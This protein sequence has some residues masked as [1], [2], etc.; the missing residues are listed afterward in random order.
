V[1][2]R[3]VGIVFGVHSDRAE[4]QLGCGADDSERDLTA[5]SDQQARHVRSFSK[6][7]PVGFSVDPDPIMP[8]PRLPDYWPP[9]RRR[10]SSFIAGGW[11]PPSMT[12]R[13]TSTMD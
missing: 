4:F 3:A 2:V 7:T 8:L 11:A 10:T 1:D 12:Q 13:R 5:V 9:G 6:S